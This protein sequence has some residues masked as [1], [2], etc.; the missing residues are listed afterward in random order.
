MPPKTSANLRNMQINRVLEEYGL[1]ERH[2]KIYLACLELGS[3][4]IQK[5]SAKSGFARSTCEA[6]LVSLQ[7]KGFVT[8]FRRKKIRYF[9]PEEPR[10]VVNLAKEKVNMLERAL[11]QFGALYYKGGVLPTARIYEGDGGIRTVLD[12][13]LEEAEE[14][15]SFGSI[16]DIQEAVPD[17][18]SR[19]SAERLAKGIPLR[20]ILKDSPLARERQKLGPGQLR[21]VRILPEKYDCSSVTYIWNEKVAM[22]SL[23]EGKVAFVIESAELAKIQR[24]MFEALWQTLPEPERT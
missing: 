2:A 20:V 5:I 7:E 11:P 21:Q 4:S 9:S 14:L 8:S 12:E 23:K 6:V 10:R 19:F 3:A 22:L 17:Y 18:F 16:N 1:K 13:I 15:T 24:A